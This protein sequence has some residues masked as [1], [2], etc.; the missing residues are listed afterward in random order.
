MEL[1]GDLTEFNSFY[2]FEEE[3]VGYL[4]VCSSFV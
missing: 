3:I 1:L 4:F 2:G